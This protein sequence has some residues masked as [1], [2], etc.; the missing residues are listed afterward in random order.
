MNIKAVIGTQEMQWIS[1]NGPKHLLDYVVHR[2]KFKTYPRL[3]KMSP[4]PLH[5]LIEPTSVCNLRCVMC[6]QSDKSFQTKEYLGMMDYELFSD[7][8][9]QAVENNCKSLTLASRGEPTLHKKFGKMLQYCK[10]KFLELKINTNAT[11]LTD[12]LS[13]NILDSGVDIV[14]FSVDSCSKK[15]YEKIRV[16]GNF[17]VVLENIKRFCKIKLSKNEYNKTTTRVSGVYF[18]GMHSRNDFRNYWKEI[19]DT[20]T[21][22]EAIPRWNTYN[23]KI[24]NSKKPCGWLWERMYVWHDGTCNPCD[25]D[26]KSTLM[27]GD[28]KRTPLK[29]I[30]L[31][32]TYD[33]YRSMH[34]RMKRKC[35]SPCNQCN[36]Y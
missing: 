8:V 4:F 29:N 2:Y 19:V 11:K 6:F 36:I 5:L 32:N 9:D 21:A 13:Y 12:E 1:N 10:N 16:K 26:Y 35:L 15:E 17:E 24:R 30:W 33:S 31:G 25:Y 7:I 28:A 14:V 23:N 27:V 20:V 18:K 22:S 34:S 3:M